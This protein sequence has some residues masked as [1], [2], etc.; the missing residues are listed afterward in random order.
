ANAAFHRSLRCEL[1]SLEGPRGDRYRRG[2]RERVLIVGGGIAGLTLAAA[3]DPRRVEV[4]LVEERPD[5]AGAGTVLTLCRPALAALDR[6]GLAE[7]LTAVGRTSE[8][9]TLR[10]SR[11]E[12]LT[13][14]R[15]PRLTFV[16][17]PELVA[18]LDAAVPAGVVRV[19]KGVT[20]PRVLAVELGADLVVG[21]DG[22]RSICRQDAFPATDPVVTDQVVL[23]GHLA[24]ETTDPTEWWGPGGLF[25][26]TPGPRG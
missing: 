21:A 7:R 9:G 12:V 14:R 2:V 22:V 1:A 20:D 19:T 6:I 18:A 4:A 24:Q 26:M 23:R 17:R 10:D 8:H 25:G 3:L 16:P 13:R 15:V 11:G 5:R